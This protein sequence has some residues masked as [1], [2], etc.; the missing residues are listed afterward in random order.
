MSA[1]SRCLRSTDD[2]DCVS[3]SASTLTAAINSFPPPMR[4]IE[5]RDIDY[6][7]GITPVKALLHSHGRVLVINSTAPLYICLMSMA[8]YGQHFALLYN[9]DLQDF[10]GYL[11]EHAVLRLLLNRAQL[12]LSD[13]CESYTRREDVSTIYRVREDS[14][15]KDGLAML[16][17]QRS[18]CLITWS[19]KRD[20]PMGYLTTRC[21]LG[22][23]IKHLRGCHLHRATRIAD[24]QPLV[25]YYTVTGDTTLG[26][27]IGLLV[28]HDEILLSG[29]DGRALC[30]FN[31]KMI[32]NYILS[33]LHRKES[34][35]L[36]TELRVVYDGFSLASDSTPLLPEVNRS[37]SLVEA[38]PI[39]LSSYDGF[40]LSS[41]GDSGPSC[42]LS[43]WDVLQHMLYHLA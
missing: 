14:P 19:S 2:R 4:R 13:T 35:R 39:I 6:M 34:V 23:I 8:A 1:S 20:A 31:R 29:S 12:N 43:V 36:S 15:A 22:Y 37:M 40:F 11:D 17:S 5:C 28:D 7:L 16:L 18:R 25:D 21:Y 9:P 32:V 41:E 10:I 27:T 30:V 38:L 24:I 26:E 3:S 42:V 33:L